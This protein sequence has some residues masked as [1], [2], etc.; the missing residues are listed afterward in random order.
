L[1]FGDCR[2]FSG[3]VDGRCGFVR[4]SRGS[5]HGHHPQ[6]ALIFIV[7]RVQDAVAVSHR[8]EKE[9]PSNQVCPI[10]IFSKLKLFNL[11]NKK[12]THSDHQVGWNNNKNCHYKSHVFLRSK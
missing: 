6:M 4:L 3:Y 11:R 9:L 5:V 10:S 12:L 2:V 8:V 7:A 1:Q